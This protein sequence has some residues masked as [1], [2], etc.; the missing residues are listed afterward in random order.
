M[1]IMCED[2]VKGEQCENIWF[3]NT[4]INYFMVMIYKLD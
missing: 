3:E 4:I 1:A 2:V